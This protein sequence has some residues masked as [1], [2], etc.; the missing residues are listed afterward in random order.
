MGKYHLGRVF[1][2]FASLGLLGCADE[3][4]YYRHDYYVHEPVYVDHYYH[5][6]GPRY[7]PQTY[8]PHN[9]G[10]FYGGNAKTVHVTPPPAVPSPSN[11]GFSGG[12]ARPVRLPPPQQDRSLVSD[13]T[14]GGFSG[15]HSAVVN[16]FSGR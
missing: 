10:G 14:H 5:H 4:T 8:P 16:N 13:D 1:L 3:S 2:M 15:G 11:G 12:S 7:Y 9:T 6:H